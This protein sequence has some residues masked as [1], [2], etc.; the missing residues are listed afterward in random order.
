[1]AWTALALK[2]SPTFAAWMSPILLGLV[3]SAPVSVLTSRAR[4][5]RALQRRNILATPEELATPSV[6]LLADQANSAVDPALD[7]AATARRGIVAAVVDP[8]VNGV[9]V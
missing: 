9:H 1:I 5:G 6:I 7:A 4:Y 2:I 3:L 8:Y